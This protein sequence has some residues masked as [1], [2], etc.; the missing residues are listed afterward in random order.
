MIDYTYN[1]DG[2]NNYLFL[3]WKYTF[4]WNALQAIFQLLNEH[5]KLNVIEFIQ[6]AFFRRYKE[7]DSN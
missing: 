5:N 4:E 3:T 2:V 7:R 6:L 1:D